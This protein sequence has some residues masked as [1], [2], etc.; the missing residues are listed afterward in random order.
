MNQSSRRPLGLRLAA[1]LAVPLLSAGCAS[2]DFA[3]A[4]SPDAVAAALRRGSAPAARPLNRAG[5]PLV[6]LALGGTGGPR[7]A[8]FDLARS[9]LLWTVAAKASGRIVAGPSIIVHADGADLVARDVTSGRERWRTGV[10]EGETLVGYA[11]EGERVFFVARRGNEL[12]GGEA[13]LVALAASNGSTD[14][15]RAL[16]TANVAGPAARGGIVAVPNK[17]QFVSLYAA[18]SGQPLAQILSKDQAANFVVGHPEGFF[19]GYGSDG[20][21]LLSPQTA[22]GVRGSPGYLRAKFPAFVRPVYH[23]DMYQPDLLGYS[24]I[25][26]NRVLWRAD[27][28]AERVTFANDTASVL[29]YR[30]FFGFDP[31]SGAL[32]W[33]YNHPVVEAAAAAHTRAAI[34]FVTVDGELGALDPRT[35]RRGYRHRLAKEIV[36]G[37]TFD[38]D[39]YAPEG[40]S[41]LPETPTLTG[42]LSSIV[43]DPDRRFFEVKLFA[44]DQLA[45]LPGRQVTADLLRVLGAPDMPP[46]VVK[47]AAE[48][49]VARKDPEAA[50]LFVEALKGRTDFA[51]GTNVANLDVLARAVGALGARDA[52]G[53]LVAHLRLPETAPAAVI[54]ICRA[55]VAL[56]AEE[57]LPVLR[58]YLAMYR[59]DP[60]YENDPGALLAVAEALVKLGGPTDREL[61]LFLAEDPRSLAPVREYVRRAL[62]QTAESGVP[63]RASAA[64]TMKP[65]R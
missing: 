23:F 36:T 22:A 3:K 6:Y 18:D 7:I 46:V 2:T 43:W 62:V 61:L 16:G 45:R 25:D 9:E 29:N 38:A 5:R 19:Y 54:E 28:Q 20:M 49:I 17:S 8:A 57:G 51:D 14:W 44:V 15:R 60:V 31:N 11:V 50:D 21:F 40:G 39:G 33:A 12:R 32:R 63:P 55:L 24:A 47:R 41:E 65:A 37:A 64:P 35:G 13:Q 56:K 27:A 4:G 34:L 59:S 53:P 30:F 42:A 10:P 1:L 48:A 58:D 52:A 26:R